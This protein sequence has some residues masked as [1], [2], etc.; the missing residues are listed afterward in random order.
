MCCYNYGCFRPIPLRMPPCRQCWS[1]CCQQ[2]CCNQ[3]CCDPCDQGSIFILGGTILGVD[4]LPVSAGLPVVFTI[5]GNTSTTTTNDQGTYAM[6]VPAN[7]SVTITP[8]P[9]LGVTITPPNYTISPV[10][11]SNMNLD[12]QLSVV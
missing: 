12:F 5:N 10:T 7:A 11:A 9:G 4:G 2:C 1:W 8:N 3:C 6:Q